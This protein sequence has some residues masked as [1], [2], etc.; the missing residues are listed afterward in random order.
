MGWRMDGFFQFML[1]LAG[2]LYRLGRVEKNDTG[3]L[4]LYARSPQ[5]QP[6]NLWWLYKVPSV[7]E[8]G[9]WFRIQHEVIF[10]AYAD[11]EFDHERLVCEHTLPVANACSIGAQT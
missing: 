10:W 7:C 6:P 2:G 9:D 8:P 3:G 5:D 4:D 1:R 11:R